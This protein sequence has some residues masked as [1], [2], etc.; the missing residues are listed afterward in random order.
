MLAERILKPQNHPAWPW[1]LVAA[2]V[3]AIGVVFRRP[4]GD[5]VEVWLTSA[6]YNYGPMVPVIA[7]LMLW[8]DNQRSSAPVAPSWVGVAIVAF[9]LLVR[10]MGRAAGLSA[11]SN[12]G[13]VVACAGLVIALVGLRRARDIWPGLVFLIFALPLSDAAQF[14]LTWR[15]Q[16]LSS[17]GGVAIINLAGIPVFREGNI[18]DMGLIQL[19]V[20]EACSGLR[21]LFP[22]ATFGFL[23]AYL[24]DAHPILRVLVFLSSLPITVVMNSVRIAVTGILADSFGL[25]AA[26]GFFHYFEG[27]AVFCLCLALLAIEM[28]A[29]VL[30]DRRGRS[31]VRR[32]DLEMPKLA[33]PRLAP[34]VPQ[35]LA[36]GGLLFVTVLA[37]TWVQHRIDVVERAGPASRAMFT[38]FPRKFD[39]WVGFEAPVDARSIEVLKPTD[40]LSVSYHNSMAEAVD[41][42]IAYY[43][44]GT[45]YHSPLICIP[46]GG[47]E[48]ERLDK[49]EIALDREGAAKAT[50]NRLIIRRGT[51]R[52]LVYYWFQGRG[53][54]EA[55][56]G[57]A[58]LQ[59]VVDALKTNRKDQALVRLV[60]PIPRGEELAAV[61]ERLR[62]FA[63]G[64]VSEL[65]PYIP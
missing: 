52:Q 27:W 44:S 38:S 53:H 3:A 29:I 39:Q 28:K 43:S 17:E 1:L 56:E 61:E 46:G 50:V 4:I 5:L 45:G 19:Q 26:E 35:L 7:L 18:I 30:L 41:L 34:A 2:V 62:S 12:I 55:D 57:R 9:A 47:W 59:M 65:R 63:P 54:V 49:A 16:L 6:E 21:Y 24:F 13:L 11:F 37:G 48:I 58:R 51:D 10:L 60:A 22:L 15:L 64:L 31:L 36:I 23:C 8:R 42:W 14:D 32:L 33:P 20:A 40:Y 25:A